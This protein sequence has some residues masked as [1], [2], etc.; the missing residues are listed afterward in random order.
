MARIQAGLD[1]EQRLQ[2]EKR[3]KEMR[4]H[5]ETVME[6]EENNRLKLLQK[7]Q[8]QEEEFKRNQAY[9]E[10][11]RLEEQARQNA[12]KK[13]LEKIEKNSQLLNSMEATQLQQNDLNQ[14]RGEGGDEKFSWGDDGKDV[15]KLQLRKEKLQKIKSEN[16]KITESKLREQEEL[17]KKD[18]EDGLKI[19]EETIKFHENERKKRMTELEKKKK[20]GMSLKHQIVENEEMIMKSAMTKPEKS[21]NKNELNLIQNDVNLHSR[22]AHRLRMKTAPGTARGDSQLSTLALTRFALFVCYHL[23]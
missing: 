16:D 18:L 6:N 1:Y 19:K 23:C 11:L 3:E 5:R 9:E 20:Y 10:R 22:I 7:Q 12:F 13:R 21:V 17:K 8:E 4:I 14:Q 15:K 2:R